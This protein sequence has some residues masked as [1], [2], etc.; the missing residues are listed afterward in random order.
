MIIDPGFKQQGQFAQ[1]QNEHSGQGQTIPVFVRH[2]PSGCCHT[3]GG[4]GG[5]PACDEPPHICNGLDLIL[6]RA[7]RRLGASP[8]PPSAAGAVR[9]CPAAS[10]PPRRPSTVPAASGLLATRAEMGDEELTAWVTFDEMKKGG[11]CMIKGNP[12]KVTDITAKVKGTGASAND[13]VV[14]TGTHYLTGKQSTDTVNLTN[15]HDGLEVP[16]T[17][18]KKYTLLDVDADSGFL[19]LLTD[20][21]DTKEDASLSKK[22]DE[23]GEETWDDVGA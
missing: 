4:A 15:A 9:P 7:A 5:S 14:I 2:Q 22:E 6:G 19:S 11:W 21:G 18:K 17:S 23:D 20:D 10:A 12:C 8:A 16:I 3:L 13:R 1:G